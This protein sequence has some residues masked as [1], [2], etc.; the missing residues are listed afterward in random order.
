MRAFPSST[1]INCT[2]TGPRV[3]IWGGVYILNY[4]FAV[5]LDFLGLSRVENTKRPSTSDPYKHHKEDEHRARRFGGPKNTDS[6]LCVGWPA[7]GGV[8]VLHTT[9]GRAREIGGAIIHNVFSMEERCEVIKRLGGFYYAN[10]K[11]CPYLDLP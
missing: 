11:D 9:R 10:P 3:R 8:W 4:C 1:T 5:E 7:V 2:R 6:Y